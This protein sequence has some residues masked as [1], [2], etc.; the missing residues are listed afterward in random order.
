MI[1][2]NLNYFRVKDWIHI[3]G[4]PILGFVHN[5]NFNLLSM[6]FVSVLILSSLGLAFAYS[7][8]TA[9]DK[10]KARIKLLPSLTVLAAALIYSS[11]LSATTFILTV[12]ESLIILAYVLPPFRVKS[13]PLL[14]TIS[15]AAAFSLLFLIGYSILSDLNT[16]VMYLAGFIALASFPAQLIH[17]I[18]DVRKDKRLDVITTPIRFG[19]E[20]TRNLILISLLALAIWSFFLYAKGFSL[21][22]PII[23]SGFSLSFYL[24]LRFADNAVKSRL[25]VRYLSIAMGLLLMTVFLFRI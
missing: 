14:V 15:N 7:F 4:I 12:I 25:Y 21:S 17:E 1:V 5:L 13:V 11:L 9:Y 23:S 8:D 22:F 24:I 10:F 20:F 2:K 19:I 3:L 6:E 16:N 18:A